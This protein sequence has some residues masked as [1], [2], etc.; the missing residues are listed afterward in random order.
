[1]A[2]RKSDVQLTINKV[3]LARFTIVCV[4][5]AFRNPS[6]IKVCH[7]QAFA[8][9]VWYRNFS[10][11]IVLIAAYYLPYS[12]V[13]I[14]NRYKERVAI[15]LHLV[16]DCHKTLLRSSER[17]AMRRYEGISNYYFV[18]LVNKSSKWTRSLFEQ[19]NN[20]L[21]QVMIMLQ[22]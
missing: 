15:L 3:L 14:D 11:C 6:S 13:Y 17:D 8:Q 2:S 18:F 9:E 16:Y 7:K 4:N 21:A 12:L 19:W 5:L 1:M 22:E 20:D 10:L